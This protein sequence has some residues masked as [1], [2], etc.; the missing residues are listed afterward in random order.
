[1][2]V[3]PNG[4]ETK[5]ARGLLPD[6]VPHREAAANAGRAA[7]MVAALGSRPD[8]LQVATRDYLHQDYREPAMPQTLALVRSLREEGHAATVSGAGPTVLVFPDGPV[9][10]LPGWA[11]GPA[12]VEAL[13]PDGWSAHHLPVDLDGVLVH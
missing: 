3:P 5:V 9:Q 1:M 2:L 13:C 8:L 11:A 4:V 12:A 6:T 7:L 10:P